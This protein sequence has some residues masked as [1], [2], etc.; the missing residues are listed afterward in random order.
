[1]VPVPHEG[2]V[3]LWVWV[4]ENSCSFDKTPQYSTYAYGP[5]LITNSRLALVCFVPSQ[6][7][8]DSVYLLA[9]W[10]SDEINKPQLSGCKMAI[11]DYD[12]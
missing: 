10:D 11:E 12:E 2:S 8:Q 5:I 4:A 9:H 7:T 6:I 1:M 3:D